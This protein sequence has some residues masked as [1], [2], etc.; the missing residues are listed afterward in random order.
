MALG[1]RVA[2]F[3]DDP[4][5]GRPPHELVDVFGLAIDSGA[6]VSAIEIGRTRDLTSSVDLVRENFAYLA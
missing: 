4:L 3:L 2:P 1:P 5:P 6:A